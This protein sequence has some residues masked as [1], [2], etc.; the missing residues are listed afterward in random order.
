MGVNSSKGFNFRLMASGSNGFTEL[1]IFKDEVITVSDNVT[2]L[3]D[4]GVLPSD[5][6]RQ[7]LVP[8]TKKNNAFFEHVYDIAVEN[9][10][11]FETNVKVPAYFDFDGLYVSQ[12][13]L[14]LNKVNV[15]ANRF[16]DS[17]EISI[18][19]TLSS[20][21]RDIN[22]LYL[23]D[24]TSSLAQYNHTASLQNITAS[25]GG[26]LFSGDIVYPLAE[27]GQK[28]QYTP[29]E[30]QFGIDSVSGSLCVQDFKPA[31]RIKPVFDAIFDAAG[32]TYS[33]SFM[34]QTF[35]DNVYMIANRQLRYPVFYSGSNG[36]N[37]INLETYGLC[38]FSPF[39]GSGQTDV[40][41]S[42]G[43][44]LKL[45]WYKIESNPGGN[46]SSNL[47]YGLNFSSSLRGEIELNFEVTQSG[48]PAGSGMPQFSLVIKDQAPATV[49][50]IPLTNINN[51]MV[52][53]KD[54]NDNTI[55]TQKFDLTT[56]FNTPML[57]S[58]SYSF[59][60]QYTK[61]GDTNFD[62]VL[63]PD[64]NLKSYFQI[65]KVSQGGDGLIMNIADN[66]PYGT[67]GIKCVDFIKGL[68]KKFNLVIYPDKTQQR[69]FIIETFND[70]YNRGETKDFNKYINLDEKIEVIP[71]NN[72]AV[73]E[74]NFGDTLDGD[75][76]SQQFQKENNREYG[77]TYYVDT[78][79]FFSQGTFDVKTT[80]AS[81]PLIYVSGTGASGSIAGQTIRAGFQ[82]SAE[83]NTA[84]A[85]GAS[86]YS[87]ITF[88]S[89]TVTYANATVFGP[90]SA[91]NTDPISQFRYRVVAVGSQ[92]QFE[93][94]G[95]ETN[96]TI[97]FY[98]IDDG[99]TTLL[100][101]GTSFTY[102]VTSA[103]V[104]NTI[105]NFVSNINSTYL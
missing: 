19:G 51:Y 27:Y 99:G 6:T 103:D 57:K 9:P 68:Q 50:T 92:I 58:G 97:G 83:I 41:M 31:I 67:S 40:L 100:S 18:F 84:N 20:F 46:L 44:D 73:N 11:L 66:L 17:Y 79:N 81:S 26:N 21:A 2:G 39:S 63:N 89:E 60:L 47:V 10:Y 76:V 43:S 30:N 104:S 78:Q 49:A 16:V 86:A 65:N 93:A 28:I 29:E 102:T 61:L 42:P 91:T 85:E 71:A 98:R 75:Y 32:Y 80:F 34:N 53:V 45:P 25:W 13:Y 48:T 5:F 4:I 95:G 70:W 55:K 54:Y 36:D 12:G 96:N 1:D 23:T 37:A 94:F 74:L 88:N 62:V 22:R 14:Q 82:S 38:K 3:F 77:K 72:L 56:E 15:Y 69:Q 8:G 59:Y 33:S 52:D 35:L 105:L 7:I 90:G 24:L 64:S 101:T 87:Q